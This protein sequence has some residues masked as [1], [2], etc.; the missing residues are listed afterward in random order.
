MLTSGAFGYLLDYLVAWALFLSLLV[1]TLCFFRLFPRRRFRRTGLVLGN[2]MVFAC[3]LGLVALGAESYLRFVHVATDSFGM[4]LPARRWF[5]L[6]TQLNSLGCRDH[7]WSPEKPPGVRRIAFVG[8]S[9]VY[10]WGIEKPQDRFSDRIQAMFD[11]R[12]P[13]TTEVLNVAKPGWDTGAQLQPV[14]DMIEVYGVDEVVLG[15]VPNDIEKLLGTRRDF[16][17]T[18]PPEPTFFNLESSC[19]LDFLF[20]RMYLPRLPTVASYHDWLADGFADEP[21][22]HKHQQQLGEMIARCKDRGVVIRAVLLPFLETRGEKYIPARLHATLRR[23]FE[24]NGVPV[25]DLYPVVET[26]P[27]AQL[28][29]NRQDA[30][31]NERAHEL[32]AGAIWEAFYAGPKN[33]VAP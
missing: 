32:F 19:L 12:A 16:N 15:Y 17:P 14:A 4:S 10:G 5:A 6:Y 11:R 8:D 2:G 29:V 1:H 26:I 25:L 30:H 33:E 18:R 28:I 20:R 21:T 23:Y 3:L 13:G 31:P 27:R 9:F 24:A 22:W 7:E